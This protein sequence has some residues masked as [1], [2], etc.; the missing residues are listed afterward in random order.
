MPLS[1]HCGAEVTGHHRMDCGYYI[2][3]KGEVMAIDLS[4]V[5][6]EEIQAA[7]HSIE[8]HPTQSRLD[9]VYGNTTVLVYRAGTVIR[10]DFKETK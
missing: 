1:C 7:V 8:D 10:A 4:S 5:K 9:F 6:W 3:P 2:E